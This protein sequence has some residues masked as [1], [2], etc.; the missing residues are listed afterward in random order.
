[1]RMEME[2]ISYQNELYIKRYKY[3][4]FREFSRILPYFSRFVRNYVRAKMV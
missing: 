1:M 2:K 4:N 3:L